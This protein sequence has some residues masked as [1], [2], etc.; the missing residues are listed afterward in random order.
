[1]RQN[2]SDVEKEYLKR[3]AE[4]RSR[5]WE[6]MGPLSPGLSD[7]DRAAAWDSIQVDLDFLESQRVSSPIQSK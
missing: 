2:L 1:M 3:L 7:S 6:R 4:L 5:L